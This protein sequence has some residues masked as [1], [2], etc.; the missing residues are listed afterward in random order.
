LSSKLG[1]SVVAPTSVTVPSSN[2]RQETVLL[3]PVEA[4][5]LID[6]QQGSLT[7]F[8]SA[9]RLLKHPLEFA[10]ARK[11]R[12][13]LHKGK[14]RLTRENARNGCFAGARR[15]PKNQA[16][17]C[18]R[19]NKPR[20]RAL[21]AKKRLLSRHLGKTLRPQPV[22]KRAR[23]VLFKMCGGEQIGHLA[24]FTLRRAP[25]GQEN[26]QTATPVDEAALR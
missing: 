25:G 13:N 24:F 10:N 6:K 9:A 12:R 18:T 15:A 11:N 4:V 7:Q 19:S 5:H 22:G 20:K 23:N 26:V 21:R 8:A 2:H 16:T 17:Q 14:F 3:C 1:F